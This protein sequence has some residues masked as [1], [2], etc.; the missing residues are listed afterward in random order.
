VV[1][2]RPDVDKGSF[3]IVWQF[4]DPHANPRVR[5]HFLIQVAIIINSRDGHRPQ[6][7]SQTSAEKC[8]LELGSRQR[9]PERAWGENGPGVCFF[10]Q[11]LGFGPLAVSDSGVS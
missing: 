5:G 1:P 4:F 3:G 11:D 6:K 10:L 9:A 2:L 8:F 7:R